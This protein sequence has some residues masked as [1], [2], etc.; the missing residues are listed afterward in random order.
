M[1]GENNQERDG[2]ARSDQ[3]HVAVMAQLDGF[4]VQ[5]KDGTWTWPVGLWGERNKTS[6]LPYNNDCLIK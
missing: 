3:G 6:D 4:S 2:W 1:R 5:P